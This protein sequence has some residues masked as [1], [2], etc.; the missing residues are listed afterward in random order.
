VEQKWKTEL[1]RV[2]N[3][4]RLELIIGGDLSVARFL[5]VLGMKVVK[6]TKKVVV[7]VGWKGEAGFEKI[8]VLHA[9]HQF[10][11]HVQ[12]LGRH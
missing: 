4:T 2:M 8:N 1:P 3:I 6:G 12:G 11:R 5:V 7:V 10:V 9:T